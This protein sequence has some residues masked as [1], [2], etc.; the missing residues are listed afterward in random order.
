MAWNPYHRGSNLRRGFG[1]GGGFSNSGV[2]PLFG[3][4]SLGTG[5]VSEGEMG[6][7]VEETNHDES[8]GSLSERTSWASHSLGPPPLCASTAKILRRVSLNRPY[9]SGKG[10]GTLG[11]SSEAC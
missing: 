4:L 5:T 3:T 9:P 6:K 11:S 2:V 7:G 8:R 10:R 1:G